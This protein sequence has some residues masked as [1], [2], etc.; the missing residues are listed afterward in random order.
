M[1]IVREQVSQRGPQGI[2]TPLLERHAVASE[3]IRA[4]GDIARHAAAAVCHGLQ[5]AHGHSLN[6][7]GQHVG[8]AVGV[9][10]FQGLAV[11]EPGEEDARVA[12]GGIAKGRLVLGGVRTA[13]GDGEALVRIELPE[14]LDQE[15][16]ALLGDEPA[17]IQQ[18]GA[19]IEPPL[20]L[21]LINRPRL[22]WLD[23]VGDE[24]RRAA[25]GTLEVGLG[26]FGQDDE[27]VGLSGSGLLPHLD[28][29]AGEPAP[30]GALPVQAVDG[31][32]GANAGALSQR[33]RHART[34]GVVVNHV[35]TVLDGSQGGEV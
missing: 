34:L 12:L 6:I 1:A 13:A 22:L 23:T 27:T 25:V 18:V 21:Y 4:L 10:L 26:R 9:Q 30:L 14:G 32:H 28:V 20:L 17:Q 3:D 29:G 19:R 35:G 11:D 33:Q 24:R 16:G 8:I 15:L 7:G 2:G 31:G 5:Q